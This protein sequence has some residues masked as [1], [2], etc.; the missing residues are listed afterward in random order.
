MLTIA[1]KTGSIIVLSMLLS[2]CVHAQSTLQ[3]PQNSSFARADSLFAIRHWK[4]AKRIYETT[5]RDTTNN[6]LEWNRLGFSDLNLGYYADALKCF[7]RSLA[8]NPPTPLKAIVFSRMARIFA[9][10]GNKREALANLDSAAASSYFNLWELDSLPDFSSIR[11]DAHFKKI[12]QQVFAVLYPCMSDPHARQ[13]DFWIGEWDVYQTG[14]N[15]YQGHSLIQMIAGG[16]ALL[17]NWDSQNS[18][19]KSINFIDPVTNTWKQ[20]WA[21]SYTAGIQEFVNGK[22]EDSAMRFSFQSTDSKGN[23]TIGRFIFYN[24]GPE[25]VRQFNETSTDGGKTWTTGYDFT[26]RRKK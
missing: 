1:V 26:Y 12:R 25:Q 9:H 18:T 20:T 19:G 2:V 7:S 15:N 10:E 14:T 5:L 8:Q 16:C 4:E 3:N 13:F 23:I 17:E 21:G 24:E 6:P 22:Y 11:N